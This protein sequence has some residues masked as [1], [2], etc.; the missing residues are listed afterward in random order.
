VLS[1]GKRVKGLNRLTVVNSLTGKWFTWDGFYSFM[2]LNV[3]QLEAP[4]VISRK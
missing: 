4:L 3:P 1:G 2:N